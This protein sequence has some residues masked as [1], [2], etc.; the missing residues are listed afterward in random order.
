MRRSDLAARLEAL[1]PEPVLR[2]FVAALEEARRRAG[3]RR[4]VPRELRPVF[5]FDAAGEVSEAELPKW[6]AREG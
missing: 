1:L 3:L 5:Y 6:S 4:R 2:D